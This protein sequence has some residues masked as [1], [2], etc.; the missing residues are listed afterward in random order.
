MMDLYIAIDSWAELYL[1]IAYKDKL[2]ERVSNNKKIS[3]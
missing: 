3:A 1:P 2:L